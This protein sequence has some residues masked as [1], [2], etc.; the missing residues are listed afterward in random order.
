AR[1]R[2][3]VSEFEYVDRAVGQKEI[4]NGQLAG[5]TDEARGR[6]Y[7]EVK[8]AAGELHRGPIDPAAEHDRV[9]LQARTVPRRVDSR[10]RTIA[11]V[12]REGIVPGGVG[13][14]LRRLRRA[15]ID[16]AG[17]PRRRQK[18]FFQ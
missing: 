5:R 13:K 11:A 15:G 6:R 8:A 12:D 16:E 9:V 1:Q 4:L 18:T 3:A 14:V 7:H 2:G 17:D 10:A